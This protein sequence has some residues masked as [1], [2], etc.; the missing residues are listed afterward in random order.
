VNRLREIL[1]MQHKL[2][3]DLLD[4]LKKRYSVL[5]HVML[6]GTVG[7]RSLSK[8]LQMT[9][10][11]LRSEVDFLRAQGLIDSHS[12]GMKLTEAGERLLAE[13]EPIIQ[14]LLGLND[15]QERL[16]R[17]FMVKQVVIVPGDADQS[18]FSKKE[19][20]R[21]GAHA[22][23]DAVRKDDIVAVTG[24]STMAGLAEFLVPTLHM[25]GNR[26]VPARGGLGESVELQANS[27]V[28]AM[29]KRTGGHYKLLHVPDHLSEEAYFTL[30]NEPHIQDVLRVIRQARVVVHGI[31]DALVMAERRKL[32]IDDMQRLR[33]DGALA[34]AFGYY[35]DRTGHVIHQMPTVGLRLEDIQETE[36]VIAVAGGRSKAL[37]IAS[38]MRFGQTDILVTD[39][40]AANEMIRQF[41]TGND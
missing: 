28:S 33:A 9:E 34:E 27:I 12:A 18:E 38:I 26:F 19:L 4:V 39:E 36:V 1:D 2:L 10:R 8:S 22:L 29:A 20:C 16:A 25:R 21:A 32:S 6:L 14:D 17:H 40:G 35:F 7:R 37:A 3:P 23:R 5:H 15:L 24:G 11:V 30:I 31:G 13:L 41:A